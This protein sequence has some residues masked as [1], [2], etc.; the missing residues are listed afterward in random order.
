MT[1]AIVLT[2][3]YDPDEGSIHVFA[4]DDLWD[5]LLQEGVFAGDAGCEEPMPG[6]G[7]DT[8]MVAGDPVN[9]KALHID[10]RHP[11]VYRP[12]IW[13][14]NSDRQAAFRRTVSE[15]KESL[16]DENVYEGF[17]Y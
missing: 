14:N 8:D 9:T 16:G 10:E 7:V 13:A 3:E 12:I 2:H 1:H 4:D 11:A 5:W 17:L 6:S 15:L